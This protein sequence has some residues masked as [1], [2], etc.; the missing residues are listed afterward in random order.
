MNEALEATANENGQVTFA[1]AVYHDEELPIDTKTELL[2]NAVLTLTGD[3]RRDA[4]NYL[5]KLRQELTN[6]FYR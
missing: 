1:S 2:E 4:E 6:E 5:A 3:Y